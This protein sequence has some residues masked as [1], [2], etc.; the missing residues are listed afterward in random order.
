MIT[1][2]SSSDEEVSEELRTPPRKKMMTES[3]TTAKA[4]A[5][6][7]KTCFQKEWISLFEHTGR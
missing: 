7:Y 5:A 4:G 6:V 3:L 2:E 1:V